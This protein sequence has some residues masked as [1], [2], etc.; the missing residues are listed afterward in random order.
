M[1]FPHPQVP[2]FSLN[3]NNQHPTMRRINLRLAI[4]QLIKTRGFT[5]LRAAMANPTESL[6]AE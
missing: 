5:L 6:R 3:Y 4:R 2:H 1:T